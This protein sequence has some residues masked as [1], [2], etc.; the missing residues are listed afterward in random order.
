MPAMIAARTN[1]ITA[2]EPI[3]AREREGTLTVL[4]LAT[5]PQSTPLDAISEDDALSI[6]AHEELA[7]LLAIARETGTEA[8]GL[9]YWTRDEAESI[10][11]A[12]E[13][14]NCDGVVLATQAEHSQRRRLLSGDTVEKVLART[15]CDVFTEKRGEKGDVGEETPIER[16]LLATSGGP[17]ARL[18]ADAHVDIVHFLDENPRAESREDGEAILGAAQRILSGVE[19]VEIELA[20]APG[21]VAEAI[22]TR[23]NEYDKTV[24]GSPTGGLLRQSAFG[25]VPESVNRQSESGVVV[26]QQDT[27]GASMYDRWIVGDRTN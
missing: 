6:E 10:L 14:E 1:A 21:D 26:A 22:V 23:S 7:E 16:I 19:N 18:A 15:E 12:V 2:L 13:N 4:Y 3:L 17:H 24:L 25:T 9:V 20:E 11:N 27:G 8:D 5:V